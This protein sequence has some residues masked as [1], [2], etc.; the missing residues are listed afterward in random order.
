VSGRVETGAST[1]PEI[2]SDRTPGGRVESAIRAANQDGRPALTAFITAGYP[3]RSRFVDTLISVAAEADVVEVGV[4]FGA[5]RH[6]VDVEDVLVVTA[7]L[8][9]VRLL[10]RDLLVRVVDELDGGTAR[11]GGSRHGER[12]CYEKGPG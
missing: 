3:R 4:P 11:S 9:R 8:V 7:V 10:L 2:T 5:L 12:E 1:R 6:A